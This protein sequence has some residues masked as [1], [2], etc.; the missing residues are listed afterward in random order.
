MYEREREQRV[1][2][3]VFCAYLFRIKVYVFLYFYFVS[4][5][6]S[7]QCSIVGNITNKSSVQSNGTVTVTTV[8][9][10]TT[11]SNIISSS[12]NRSQSSNTKENVVAPQNTPSVKKSRPKTSSPTRHGPQQCQ[13]NIVTFAVFFF[14]SFSLSYFLHFIFFASFFFVFL[15]LFGFFTSAP[16]YTFVSFVDMGF[17]LKYGLHV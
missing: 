15:F 9:V 8:P 10:T 11:N 6:F 3:R 2:V 12:A 7:F 1:C 16:Q 4:A 14:R 5:L 13:V 17:I